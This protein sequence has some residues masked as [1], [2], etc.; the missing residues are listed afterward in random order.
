MKYSEKLK[1]PRWQKKRLE[2]FERDGWTCR[3]C[4]DKET[5]L[6]VHHLRYIHGKE[7]WDYPLENFL[8]LCQSCHDFEYE[9]RKDYESDLLEMIKEK[10]FLADEVYSIC[11]A[12]MNAVIIESPQFTA[13]L[14]EKTL[15]NK[16]IMRDLAASYK[17]WENSPGDE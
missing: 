12:F 1:D 10:G 6:C 13:R 8:T 14:I 16:A 17:K 5:M 11:V 3:K 15:S 2:V 9:V 4:K 7:P